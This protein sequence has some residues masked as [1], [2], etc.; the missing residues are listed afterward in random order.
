M[1][2]SYITYA[3]RDVLFSAQNVNSKIRDQYT[4]RKAR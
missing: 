4:V 3:S 2:K 1:V